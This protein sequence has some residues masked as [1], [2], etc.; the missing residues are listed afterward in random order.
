[1]TRFKLSRFL[2]RIYTEKEPTNYT[3]RVVRRC[4]ARNTLWQVA[5]LPTTSFRRLANVNNVIAN[6]SCRHEGIIRIPNC[7][8]KLFRIWQDQ[9]H[10]KC[11]ACKFEVVKRSAQLSS[12]YSR[13]NVRVRRA[14]QIDLSQRGYATRY[15]TRHC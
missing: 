14:C 12:S 6:H 10:G 5:T 8:G 11:P 3:R 15:A 4:A 9:R 7:H 13:E 1:M 2:S